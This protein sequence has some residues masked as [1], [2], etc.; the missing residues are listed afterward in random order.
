[1]SVALEQTLAAPRL[2]AAAPYATPLWLWPV[3]LLGLG[4]TLVAATYNGLEAT[5]LG[6]IIAAAV[7]TI[8]VAKPEVGILLLM[9]NY[10]IASYPTPLR[11]NGLITINNLLGIILAVLLIAKLAQNLDFWFL[12]NRQVKI[13]IA[14]GAVLII[15]TI[16]SSYTFP[17]LVGTRGKFRELDQ[18]TQMA[19]DFVTR[20]AFLVFTLN[21]LSTKT[22]L[23]RVV[24]V[25]M[26]CLLMVVPSALL[27][28]ASGNTVGGR[29]AAAF[30]LGTNPNRLAFL[31]LIQIPFWWYFIRAKRSTFRN[32]LGIGVIGSLIITVFLTAS[33]SGVLGLGMIFYL[34]TQKRAGVGG[35]RLQIIALGLVAVGILLTVIPQEN[36]DRMANVN[37]FSQNKE[38]GAGAHS[39]ERRVETVEIGWKMFGDHPWF[40]V[41]IGNFREVAKQVYQDEFFRPPHNSYV[42]ALTEGGIFC[43]LL[44]LLL[45][46]FTWRDI[47]WIDAAPAMPVELRWIAAALSPAM[48]LLMFYSAF[49]DIWLSPVTYIIIGLVI[50]FKRYLGGRRAVLA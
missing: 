25:M 5:V 42:W 23:K 2:P 13:F 12:R 9:T 21:F 22:D 49:A 15:S 31:C 26:L 39:T 16:V 44:Y 46:W 24:T 48:I 1:V 14:I 7:L 45:F 10:L 43:F 8:V 17:N 38:Q 28:Y 3:V 40:G 6:A 29:A 47:K 19:Q 33:R 18:T 20:L 36:L 32:I 41:G 34:L 4:A 30:S 35:G 11:G 50:V 37:P 27:G